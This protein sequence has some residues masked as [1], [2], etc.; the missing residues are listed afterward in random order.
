MNLKNWK[1]TVNEVKR[2][3][4]VLPNPKWTYDGTEPWGHEFH[5]GK[6]VRDVYIPGE[7]D[8]DSKDTQ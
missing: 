1:E 8:T 4:Y 2:G 3:N 6:H 7:P 5:A